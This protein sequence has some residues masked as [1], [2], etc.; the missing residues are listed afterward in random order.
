MKIQNKS[1]VSYMFRN[2]WQLFYI[3]LPVS[4]LMAFFC[5]PS[6]E[7]RLFDM[8]LD[9][10]LNRDNLLT[11]LADAFTLL[12]FSN[13]W[14]IALIALVCVAMAMCLLVVKVDRHMRI[15]EMPAFPLKRAV[16]IF[17][18][19]LLYILC[20]V[21]V[22]EACLLVAV[23]VV[24][25]LRFVENVTVLVA[26]SWALTFVVRA[27]LTYMFGLL[28]MSFPLKYSENYRFNVAM[29]YSARTMS[30]KRRALVLLGLLFP[31]ARLATVAV[32]YLL[33]PYH[34]DVLAYAVA[35]FFGLTY[36]PCFAFKQYYD[37]VGGERRDV[38]RVMWR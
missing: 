19:M 4:V 26:I 30:G 17:P 36:V 35:I 15:G 32:G 18:I 33:Q 13:N 37:T 16:G 23:G 31:I 8:L 22:M 24:Y 27:L 14:W 28:V 7:I 12:R 9:G 38:S 29:S 25:L 34:L 11:S 6:A 5:N 10:S 20:W 3:T 1:S 2:F 21:A